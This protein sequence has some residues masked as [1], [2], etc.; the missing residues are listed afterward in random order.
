M[1]GLTN[2]IPWGSNPVGIDI[3]AN[4]A[5]LMDSIPRL[6]FF[7]SWSLLPTDRALS[8]SVD[9]RDYCGAHPNFWKKL[10]VEH[11]AGPSPLSA[12]EIVDLDLAGNAGR[13]AE[14]TE[15]LARASSASAK[16]SG[17]A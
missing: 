2:T 11:R 10:P 15:A 14:F 3:I 5:R 9:G 17:G 6:P 16:S 4:V 1:K 7:A 13:L 8:F 12:I